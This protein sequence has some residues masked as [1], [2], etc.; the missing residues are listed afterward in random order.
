MF[1]L[2][3]HQSFLVIFIAFNFITAQTPELFIIVFL[4]RCCFKN[5]TF[6]SYNQHTHHRYSLHFVKYRY[7]DILRISDLENPILKSV[8]LIYGF[9]DN[10]GTYIT[11]RT[12]NAFDTCHSVLV[13]IWNREHVFAK[14]LANQV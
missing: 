2:I 5:S 11:D 13:W 6:K 9:D 1:K 7:M 12:R 4:N 10:D 3:C 14:S 8:L